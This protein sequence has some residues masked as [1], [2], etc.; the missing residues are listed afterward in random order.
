MKQLCIIS[1]SHTGV[2]QSTGHQNF[3]CRFLLFLNG[4]W[5]PLPFFPPKFPWGDAEALQKGQMRRPRKKISKP[6]TGQWYQYPFYPS[7]PRIS[8]SLRVDCQWY[9]WYERSNMLFPINSIF[10]GCVFQSFCSE[11][12]SANNYSKNNVKRPV[13]SAQPIV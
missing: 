9:S 6:V 10:N 12:T 3:T 5:S 4:H 11:S 2:M 1:F 8:T 13:A 7:L